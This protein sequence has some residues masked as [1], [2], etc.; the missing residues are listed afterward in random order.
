[1]TLADTAHGHADAGVEGL[2]PAVAVAAVAVVYAVAAARRHTEARGWSRWRTAS[3][4]TGAALL[5]AAF[6]PPVGSWAEHDFRGHM[7]QHLLLGMLGPLGLVLGAPVTLLL[8]SVTSRTGQAIGK[9]L[10]SGPAHAIA[11]PFTALVLNLGGLWAVYFTPLYAAT[12]DSPLLHH[13]VH[14]HFLAAGLLFAWVIAGPDPAPRRP[15]VPVRLLVLG[16]AVTA[17]ATFAQLLYADLWVRVP[18]P[19]EELRG[20]AEIMYFGGD[21]AEILLAL[22]LLVTW[23]PDRRTLQSGGPDARWQATAAG[24]AVGGADGSKPRREAEVRAG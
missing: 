20:G 1:M 5:A 23:R 7:L 10:R 3:F 18:V 12:A 11:N 9:I 4:L 15:P 8:R 21:I 24:P 16:I 19:I 17:H 22:A 13:L 2:L 14:V 6:L